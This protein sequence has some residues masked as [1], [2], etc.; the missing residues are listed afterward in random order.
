[1]SCDLGVGTRS[2]KKRG[3]RRSMAA[4]REVPDDLIADVLSRLPPRSLAVSRCVCRS[5]RDVVDTRRLLRA[6]LLPCSV[7][8]IFINF[9][10]L[11]S[12]EFFY[13]PTAAG[14][15][16]SG[17]LD[18][19]DGFSTVEDHC[20]GLLLIAAIGNDCVANPALRWRYWLPPC[21]VPP[22]KGEEVEASSDQIKCLAY[23]P[24]L[25]P[26]YEVFLIPP[27]LVPHPERHHQQSTRP[28]SSHALRVFSSMTGCWEER[29]FVLEGGEQRE[30]EEEGGRVIDK[31]YWREALYVLCETGSGLR[32][33][34]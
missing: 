14:P 2:N 18:F 33:V 19:I 15:S 22:R 25:S 30:E 26:Y 34:T 28:P 32:Y 5:W 31:L 6:D 8:G 16:I 13:R 24:A 10:A 4:G 7:G 20:N 21:P 27:R 11:D 3:E 23:D 12:P 29:S 1:V 9:C 17:D